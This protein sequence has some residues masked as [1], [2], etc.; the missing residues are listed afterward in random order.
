[1][2]NGF[3]LFDSHTHMGTARHRDRT[4]TADDLLRDMDRHGVDRSMAIPYPVVAEHRE[5]HDLIGRAA[6]AHPD[7]LAG[8]ACLY[9]YIPVAEFRDEVKRCRE[10]YGFSALKLQPQYHGLNPFS[11]SSDFFFETAFEN[12][13]AVICHTGTG[14]PFAS[15]ALCMMPARRFPELKIVL[16]HCGGGIYVHEAIVAALF[17]PNIYLEM[18][19]LMP[20][21]VRE[22]LDHVPSDRLMIGSDLP[23]SVAIE[24]AKILDME[25]A[26]EDKRN[27]LSATAS[28]VFV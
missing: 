13:M 18:S 3:H 9:P 11:A 24:F 26:D 28:R 23:E 12:G 5:Q 10:V 6:L 8:A 19:S 25:I 16:G 4:V 22:V 21:H 14:M 7:R 20:H 17:C 27:I 1:M 15:P 2:K